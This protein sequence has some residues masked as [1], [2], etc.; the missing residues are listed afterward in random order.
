VRGG[1]IDLHCV[2]R[3]AQLIRIAAVIHR[4]TCRAN[5]IVRNVPPSQYNSDHFWHCG[6]YELFDRPQKKGDQLQ[7]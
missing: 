4:S 7:R 1:A 6:P 5:Q 2:G 3:T